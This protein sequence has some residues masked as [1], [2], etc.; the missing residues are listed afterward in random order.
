MFLAIFTASRLFAVVAGT[1]FGGSIF[2]PD[3]AIFSSLFFTSIGSGLFVASQGLIDFSEV[4]HAAASYY[5]G[6]VHS[7]ATGI[8]ANLGTAGGG[9]G[10]MALWLGI[11]MQAVSVVL[12]SF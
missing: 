2:R 1:C 10:G 3:V 5:D 9:G 11:V 7:R 12:T 6:S 4:L 8:S